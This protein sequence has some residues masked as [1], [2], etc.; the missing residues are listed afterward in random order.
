MIAMQEAS[1]RFSMFINKPVSSPLEWQN[2]LRE[3]Y[4]LEK[5]AMNAIQEAFSR[6]FMLINGYISFPFQA[7]SNATPEAAEER[8]RLQDEVERLRKVFMIGF[9]FR[10]AEEKSG[11]G[12]WAMDGLILFSSYSRL[13]S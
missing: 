1:S 13:F 8:R 10:R 7:S 3:S 12:G 11:G 2:S 4:I 5:S 6:F 9:E